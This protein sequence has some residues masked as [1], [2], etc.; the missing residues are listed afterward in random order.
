MAKNEKKN[1]RTSSLSRPQGIREVKQSFL[2]V[3][4][5]MCT[6]PDYFK[7]FRMPRQPSRLSVKG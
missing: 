6:E 3:C 1:H 5:G 2:I 4:E 7:A